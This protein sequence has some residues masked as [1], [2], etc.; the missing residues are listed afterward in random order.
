MNTDIV[1]MCP[2]MTCVNLIGSD[3]VVGDESSSPRQYSRIVVASSIVVVIRSTT[4]E[5]SYSKLR[6]GIRKKT[7]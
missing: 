2:D 1:L 5:V 7:G 3:N 4:L 6:Y